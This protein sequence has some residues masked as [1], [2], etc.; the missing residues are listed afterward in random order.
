M[1]VWIVDI[2]KDEWGW[3]IMA[4]VFKTCPRKGEAHASAKFSFLFLIY[5]NI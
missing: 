2:E 1:Q 3:G 4:M 5:N